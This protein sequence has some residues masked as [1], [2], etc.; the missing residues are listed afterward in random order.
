MHKFNLIFLVIVLAIGCVPQKDILYLQD[1]GLNNTEKSFANIKSE[2]VIKVFDQIYI[3]VSSFD[4]G[5]INFMNN[6]PNRYGGGRSELDLAM[7]SYTVDQDGAVKLPIVGHTKVEGLTVDQASEK[8]RQKLEDYLNTPSVKITFVNKSITVLGS[9][10]QPGRFFYAAEYLSIF[11]AL[12]LAGDISEYG[13]RKEIVIVRDVNN[14]VVRKKVNLTDIA[15]LGEADL[16]VQ[17]GDVIYVEPLK[18]RHWGFSA[19]PWAVV[20][21]SITTVILVANYV[22]Q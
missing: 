21:S 19:F 20:L 10:N 3:Q 13:N 8:I 7:V 11:Q 18:R 4:D 16:Y 22:K 2:N 1:S 9:V 15:L 5:N 14:T 6:D 17:P 12:G